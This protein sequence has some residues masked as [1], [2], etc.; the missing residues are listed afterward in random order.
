MA[1]RGLQRTLTV[2]LG[3]RPEH[4]IL[5]SVDPL[6]GGYQGEDVDAVQQRL[7]HAVAAIPGV[8]G[9]A[10]ANSTPLSAD[11]SNTAIWAPGTTDFSMANAKFNAI[12]KSISP[13]YFA[14]AGTQ[15]LSGRGFTV[16]DDANAPQVA[17]VNATFARR[18]FGTVNAVG[19]SFPYGPKQTITVVGVIEDGKYND[20]VEAPQAAIF[21]PIQQQPDN[22]TVLLVRS[23]RS[24]AEMI[25][26]V[27][28]AIA[29]VD[30]GM[31]VINLYTWTD[32]LSLVTCPARAAT[33][34]LGV[35]GLLAVLLAVTGIV[36][37]ANYTVARRMRELGIRVALGAQEPTC[38]AR[39]A[40]P[41]RMAA[42][43]AC[44]SLAGLLLGVGVLCRPAGQHRVSVNSR[45]SGRPCYNSRDDGRVGRCSGDDSRTTRF[46]CRS[47]C[48]IAGRV[49]G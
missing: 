48:A 42:W 24:P 37:Q 31:P 8:S 18:L 21:W 39:G 40:G 3:F 19:K 10:Y 11:Q 35:L 47:C 36:G 14:V 5:A 44:S 4:V 29:S 38:T 43:G 33:A 20:L 9:V 17:V 12:K 46:V 28:H 7:L 2:P 15:M 34:A 22:D 41:D 16:H 25:P 23:E 32:A 45:R 49:S 26:A 27:Q 1:L 13:D 6:M 30:A